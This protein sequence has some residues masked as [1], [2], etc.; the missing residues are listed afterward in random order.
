[1]EINYWQDAR[2]CSPVEEFI[3]E[4]GNNSGQKPQIKVLKYIRIFGEKGL[5]MLYQMP[6]Q[7]KQLTL[8]GEIALYEL[9]I[10]FG[11][12]AYR[13]LF[14]VLGGIAYFLH[15]FSKKD[16]KTPPSE[17]AVALRRYE[18]LKLELQ[19]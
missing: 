17:I 6:E 11:G 3:E 13:I 5:L 8:D 4:I 14:V 1:M 18:L 12:N 19:I 10:G 15:A 16:Q 2:G 7:L 9:R